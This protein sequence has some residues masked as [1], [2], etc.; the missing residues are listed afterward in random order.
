MLTRY[1]GYLYSLSCLITTY[2]W[3]HVREKDWPGLGTPDRLG[4]SNVSCKITH[5]PRTQNHLLKF[6][7]VNIKFELSSASAHHHPKA[8]LLDAHAVLS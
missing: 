6:L 1:S 3:R 2:S 7:T 5:V 4:R 8:G